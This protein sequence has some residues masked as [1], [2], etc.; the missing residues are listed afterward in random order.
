MDKEKFNTILP[1]ITAHLVDKIS[2]SE[3]MPEDEAIEN[4]YASE[5]Y[6]FLENERTK[7]WQYSTQKLYDLYKCEKSNGKLELPEY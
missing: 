4:L 3:N 5:L 2:T 1:V 6:V 7:V